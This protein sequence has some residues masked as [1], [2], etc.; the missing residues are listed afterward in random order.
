MTQSHYNDSDIT[1][2]LRNF[3]ETSGHPSRN[4]SVLLLLPSSAEPRV[5]DRH[6]P[7]HGC[8]ETA[9]QV[10]ANLPW[11]SP[12]TS[13]SSPVLAHGSQCLAAGDPCLLTV[14]GSQDT[15]S[16]PGQSSLPCTARLSH[17]PASPSSAAPGERQM[18]LI[19][20]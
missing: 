8:T 20:S 3:R 16:A 10:R 7:A 19:S 11:D 18:S 9:W 13:R 5:W 4:S 17:S 14:R 1:E 12:S 2:Q 15:G 6:C